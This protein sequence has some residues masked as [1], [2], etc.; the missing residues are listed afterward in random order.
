MVHQISR[1]LCH[2]WRQIFQPGFISIHHV[3]ALLFP[4]HYSCLWFGIAVLFLLSF[5][6]LSDIAPHSL[7]SQPWPYFP[8]LSLPRP[9]GLRGVG[10]SLCH[11]SWDSFL[12]L[13]P[14]NLIPITSNSACV[15]RSFNLPLPLIPRQECLNGLP[16]R[17]G[18]QQM[19]RLLYGGC[20]KLVCVHVLYN[21]WS[22][23][24][25]FCQK[26]QGWCCFSMQG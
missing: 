10:D 6:F 25:E 12:C 15:I 1:S 22:S 8:P 18:H 20:L 13:L 21:T 19:V 9:T 17:W 3:S 16:G 5:L 26:S 11:P 14:H 7:I 2:S 24:G 4:P 23:I